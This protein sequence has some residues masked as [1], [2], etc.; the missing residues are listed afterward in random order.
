MNNKKEIKLTPL[1]YDYVYGSDY[2]VII[3]VGGR[4]SAKSYNSEIEMA[5]NLAQKKNYRLLVIEDLDSGLDKGY[6]QGLKDK[7]EQFEQ[8]KAYGMSRSPVR[9]YNKINK[10]EALF[11]G[12]KSEQQKK[13]VKAIDQVTEILVE[14]GEWLEY[15]DFVKLLHQ[16]RG[17]NKEDNKLNILMNPVNPDCFVNEMFIQTKPDKVLEYFPNSIRPKVFE[18][19]IVTEFEYEGKTYTDSTKVLIV[20]STHH[21]NPYLTIDQRASIEK[22]RETDPDLYLQLGEARFINSK[23]AFFREF[24]REIH[25]I[26]PFIIPRH[27]KRYVSI[28]YGLDM[29]AALWFAIDTNNKVYVYKELYES[30]LVISEAAARFK[31]VNG[32]DKYECIYAPPDLWNRRQETGKSAI[33][34]FADNGVGMVKSNNKRVLGWLS[35][36]E[37][38]KV[39]DSRDE[40]TG[41]EIKTSNLKIFDNCENLIRCLPKV[42][43]CDKDP[44][45]VANE[46]HEL[47][48]ILDALRGYCMMRQLPSTT[49][50]KPVDRDSVFIEEKSKQVESIIEANIDN[51]FINY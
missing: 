9:I 31:E 39:I 17:R 36:K 50:K 10:N 13:A 48:H 47:S 38:I 28:D 8:D 24:K 1:Y 20:L 41:Q 51:S 29:F 23:G 37:H 3:Q 2:K 46:P 7:I 32:I 19:S 44:N 30:D 34:I 21:D 25:V 35:V 27:W 43:K 15:D 26:Q 33:D 11:H 6:Y 14:E 45:D 16:L 49:P 4:F 42:Q 22:L 5:C 12:F 40:H 18:K